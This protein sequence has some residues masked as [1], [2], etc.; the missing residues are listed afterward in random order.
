MKRQPKRWERWNLRPAYRPLG[1]RW[2]RERYTYDEYMEKLEGAIRVSMEVGEIQGRKWGE[3]DT[4]R[5]LAA[6]VDDPNELVAVVGGKTLANL[7]EAFLA[8]VVEDDLIG[9]YIDQEGD[10][11]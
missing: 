9:D 11:E 3:R 7:C 1:S 4:Y 10:S 6:L 8:V 5:A 2:R